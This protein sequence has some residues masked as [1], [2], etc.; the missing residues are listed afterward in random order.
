MT[1]NQHK[2][3]TVMPK[4]NSLALATLVAMAPAAAFAGKNELISNAHTG[5]AGNGNSFYPGISANG[6][7]VAFASTSSNLVPGDTNNRQDIFVYDR[8]LGQTERVSV[9]SDGTQ[10][11]GESSIY[12]TMS[13]DGRYV[14]FESIA[15]NLVAGDTNGQIDAFVHDRLTGVT[16][17]VSVATNGA[18]GNRYS[19][20]PAISADGRFVAFYTGASLAGNPF[21]QQGILVR[22]RLLGTTEWA[23]RPL[24][25]TASAVGPSISADGRYIAFIGQGEFLPGS[26]AKG[27][28]VYV[29]DRQSGAFEAVSVSDSGV[30]ANRGSHTPTISADGR[31]VVFNSQSWNL[32]SDRVS[33][34]YENVYIRDRQTR[35]TELVSATLDG[36]MPLGTS[37]AG[38]NNSMSADG[39]YVVFFSLANNLVGGDTNA[40]DVFVRDRQSRVIE[41][42][43]LTELDAEANGYNYGGSISA[44]ARYVTFYSTA[45]NLTAND[46]NGAALDVFVRDRVN[47]QP[48]FAFAGYDQLVEATA[49]QTPVTLDGAG[50]SDPDGD[51]LT[52]TWTGAFGIATGVSPVVNFGLGSYAI[53]MSV[54][55]GKGGIASDDVNVIVQDTT[56]PTLNVPADI[57]VTATGPSTTVNLGDATATDIFLPVNV[58]NDAPGTFPVG[59]TTVTWSAT[60]ANGNVSN[61]TQ[62]VSVVYKF[63]GFLSPL[64]AGGVYK[65]GRTLPVKFQLFYADGSLVTDATA[66]ITVQKLSSGEVVGEPIVVEATNNPDG[67]NTFR[68]TD[69]H[70]QYNLNTGFAGKGEYRI[71]VDLGDGSPLKMID[72]AFK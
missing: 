20:Y 23:T 36:S 32:T 48:P 25:G 38:F 43:S 49:V 37:R 66:T 9:A 2:T 52:Y 6:R 59:S 12:V 69:D 72:I 17:R 42:I 47:N 4:L 65:I 41:R 63:G 45:T 11:N 28:Q 39:R 24:S 14:A 22:D 10:A 5:A 30:Y 29:V 46:G 56:A 13:A 26:A 31:Y 60:D 34:A 57:S 15:S 27:S 67:G 3:G 18:Q 33:Q 62:T 50:S 53:Q 71:M 7:Y 19:G 55:D 16:E 51:V 61:A 1:T 40:Y 54:D 70:Y 8:E 64:K 21:G 58:T 35:K 44:D 68:F